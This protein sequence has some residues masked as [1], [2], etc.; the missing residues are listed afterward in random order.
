MIIQTRLVPA[1]GIQVEEP[2][3]VLPLNHICAGGCRALRF[4]MQELQASADVA[5]LSSSLQR[6]HSSDAVFVDVAPPAQQDLAGKSAEGLAPA[7]PAQLSSRN[8]GDS[9]GY[10]PEEAEQ[11]RRE[12]DSS[13][14]RRRP[15]SGANGRR[16][17]VTLPSNGAAD[18]ERSPDGSGKSPVTPSTQDQLETDYNPSLGTM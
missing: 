2:N 4:M 9:F 11:L 6:V 3:R 14:F 13:E 5:E 7:P 12:R 16:L 18:S 17:Q 10:S 1:A 8:S 15:A